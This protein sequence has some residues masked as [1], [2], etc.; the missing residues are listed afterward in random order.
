MQRLAHHAA[1]HQMWQSV[2]NTR[3]HHQHQWWWWWAVMGCR[4]RVLECG[5]NESDW[6]L[7][8]WVLFGPCQ[9]M[10]LSFS[11]RCWA[12]SDTRKFAH[13]WNAS[14]SII[15]PPSMDRQ[16]PQ[17]WMVPS[18]M[19]R[20]PTP[21]QTVCM[22]TEIRKITSLSTPPHVCDLLVPSARYI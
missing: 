21:F 10:E 2:D 17:H 15:A 18:R 22:R 14:P 19:S 1:L 4:G 20:N 5:K 13:T 16:R 11:P 6:W 8:F 7:S 12:P 9:K 3:E